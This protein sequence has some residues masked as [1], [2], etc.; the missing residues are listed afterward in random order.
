MVFYYGSLSWLTQWFRRKC[1]QIKPGAQW[2]C[3]TH[4]Q[5]TGQGEPSLPDSMSLPSFLP[6]EPGVVCALWHLGKPASKPV[7]FHTTA[8]PLSYPATSVCQWPQHRWGI[9]STVLLEVKSQAQ[10]SLF[11]FPLF[12]LG[13]RGRPRNLSWLDLPVPGLKHTFSE[14]GTWMSPARRVCSCW[15]PHSCFSPP[16]LHCPSLLILVSLP[17]NLAHC[18]PWWATGSHLLIWSMSVD[19]GLCAI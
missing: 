5:C 13:Q 6:P 19:L 3:R 2:G 16:Q 9:L 4:S 18:S 7:E 17:L 12:V 8:E 1:P 14:E 15:Q 11:T 10:G